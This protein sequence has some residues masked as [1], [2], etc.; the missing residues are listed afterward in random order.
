M[1]GLS[2]WPIVADALVSPFAFIIASCARI[3]AHTRLFSLS[4]L[5]GIFH[6]L[7][8]IWRLSATN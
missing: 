4:C 6:L 5:S 8:F 2:N 3:L 7:D 1:A